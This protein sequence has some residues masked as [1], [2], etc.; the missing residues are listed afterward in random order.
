MPNINNSKKLI[1]SNVSK[2]NIPQNLN[3]FQRTWKN[4]K[5]IVIITII[6]LVVIALVIGFLSISFTKGVKKQVKTNEETITNQQDDLRANLEAQLNSIRATG[7]V[8]GPQGPAGMMG[9]PGGSYLAAG[10]LTN[11]AI[12]NLVVDR[13]VGQGCNVSYLNLKNRMPSQR[14]VLNND[15]TIQ[16]YYSINGSKGKCMNG[17]SIRTCVS[18]SGEFV[19]GI[20]K[21]D[22]TVVN[23]REK[24]HI[25]TLGHIDGKTAVENKINFPANDVTIDN[26]NWVF[27]IS[28]PFPFM[29]ATFIL[30]SS[31]DKKIE[32]ANPFNNI[33]KY[34]SA[35]LKTSIEDVEDND[36]LFMSLG[37]TSTDS[38]LLIELAKKSC[39]FEFDP[40]SGEPVG[41]Q[42]EKMIDTEYRRFYERYLV[43]RGFVLDTLESAVDKL[44]D[45][46]DFV[47]I[48]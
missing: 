32:N 45:Q 34:K 18:T 15:N 19:Y 17:L 9:P 33:K 38:D 29:G 37:R 39:L 47:R 2:G 8:P 26:A 35:Q 14:W 46:I 13:S 11:K 7:G 22:Y 31:A 4:H 40:H 6:L 25:A 28:N 12:D 23:L 1:N 42:Y 41:I 30:K 24:D 27:E 10:T 16:N 36:A 5:M 44:G 43:L 20:H 21:P 48:K 3:W